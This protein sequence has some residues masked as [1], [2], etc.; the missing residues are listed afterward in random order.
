[1]KKNKLEELKENYKQIIEKNTK[2]KNN[3]STIR[4]ILFVVFVGLLILACFKKGFV[5]IFPALS[6]IS[7]VVVSCFFLNCKKPGAPCLHIP[8]RCVSVLLS[9]FH[10]PAAGVSFFCCKNW[11]ENLKPD[12]FP[13]H[14]TQIH[15]REHPAFSASAERLD[16]A[17]FHSLFGRSH[18]HPDSLPE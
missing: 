1:M 8:E 3:I 18:I 14:C 9:H 7:F 11:S 13:W 6:F 5:F 2:I 12:P 10:L 4:L 15:H 17:Q 16:Y